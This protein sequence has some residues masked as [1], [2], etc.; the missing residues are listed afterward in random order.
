MKRLIFTIWLM[1]IATG[2]ADNFGVSE[3]GELSNIG[4]FSTLGKIDT[5]EITIFAPGGTE[6]VSDV[7]MIA[8]AND[9]LHW[10]YATALDSPGVNLVYIHYSIAGG[11]T[12]TISG[13]HR[14]EPTWATANNIA[15]Y[16]P[17]TWKMVATGSP[18]TISLPVSY[19][20]DGDGDSPATEANDFCIGMGIQPKGGNANSEIVTIA[21]F[22][23]ADSTFTVRPGFESAPTAGDT[24]FIRPVR[25]AVE[26]SDWTK[27]EVQLTATGHIIYA[28]TVAY[29][30][31]VR[32]VGGGGGLTAEE[33]AQLDSLI[34][35]LIDSV[36][37]AT[38]FQALT[39]SPPARYGTIHEKLGQW[40]GTGTDDIKSILGDYVA[41]TIMATLD[42]T[43]DR[44]GPFGDSSVASTPFT[45]FYW[46]DQ[47]IRLKVDSILTSM[48]FDTTDLHTKV[49]ALV[50]AGIGANT[51]TLYVWDT[52][53]TITV[54][55]INVRANNLS[56]ANQGQNRSNANGI[57]VLNLDDGDYNLVIS[58][59]SGYIQTTN[60]QPFTVSGATNDTI[61]VTWF[62]PSAPAGD[63]CMVYN[64]DKGVYDNPFQGVWVTATIPQRFWPLRYSG[65]AINATHKVKTDSLGKWELPIYPSVILETAQGDSA[66]YWRISA[67]KG[68]KPLI[69]AKVTVPDSA[70]FFMVPDSE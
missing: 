68:S 43:L 34:T 5:A 12:S 28:D 39:D 33:G 47:K 57:A 2:W 49:D 6:I 50:G 45:V 60:P 36:Y 27:H 15:A 19:I 62:S 41:R 69:D 54:S 66:S 48:G 18:T 30:D 40:A 52:G 58:M 25:G 1:A 70:T 29:T 35:F 8:H 44:I 64:Y 23:I 59:N 3:K 55:G 7:D 22:T 16:P 13:R 67:Y 11:D 46:L 31:T 56:G 65:Q 26:P 4:F 21:D 37:A 61:K 42:S 51:C 53:N 9:S 24:I 20:V 32:G 63:I 14:V 10:N 17:Y 38:G